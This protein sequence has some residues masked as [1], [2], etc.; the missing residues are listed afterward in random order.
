[1]TPLSKETQELRDKL[2]AAEEKDKEVYMQRLWN[3]PL[4]DLSKEGGYKSELY[5]LYVSLHNFF[6]GGD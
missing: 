4:K 1:M 6:H 3:T 5:D 2:R